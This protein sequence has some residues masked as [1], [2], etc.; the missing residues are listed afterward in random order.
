MEDITNNLHFNLTIQDY[1]TFHMSVESKLSFIFQIFA[2]S[3]NNDESINNLNLNRLIVVSTELMLI[4][5]PLIVDN[6]TDDKERLE[7]KQK[8]TNEQ[9]IL[10]QSLEQL[11]DVGT[12]NNNNQ[13]STFDAF[14]IRTNALKTLFNTNIK[15]NKTQQTK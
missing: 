5:D 12:K 1:H 6:I 15:M 7:L 11:R 9:N 14:D 3:F 4:D 8:L 10:R 2:D 13:V